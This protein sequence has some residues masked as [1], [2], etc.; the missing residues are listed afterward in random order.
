[1][2]T[3]D[4]SKF[5][6]EQIDKKIKSNSLKKI[7]RIDRS[8]FPNIQITKPD[9]STYN[10]TSFACNDYLG[11]SVNKDVKQAVAQATLTN[12][13]G[14]GGSKFIAGY[15][16]LAKNLEINLAKIKGFEKSIVFSSG[17]L[18][19]I[20]VF[21]SIF[22]QNDIIF[23]D[24]EIHAS[25]IDGILLSKA[26]LI[27]YKHLDLNH[28]S[29]LIQKNKI[30][31][32][33]SCKVA[34]VS[35]SVF[36]MS[37]D[38]QDIQSLVNIA[39]QYGAL[40]IIDDAHGFGVL[41]RSKIINDYQFYIQTGTFSKA[42]GLY[43]GYVCCSSLVATYVQNYARSGIYN[44]FLPPNTIAGIV[45]SLELIDNFDPKLSPVLK[46][47]L[48]CDEFNRLFCSNITTNSAI[49]CIDFVAILQNRLKIQDSY[50]FHL[51]LC[52]FLLLRGM[53]ARAILPPT[54]QRPIVRFTFCSLH[55][56]KVIS[57]LARVCFDFTQIKLSPSL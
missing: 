28:L 21:S 13:L 34:I 57:D 55:S 44:T 10:A 42:V 29:F 16:T 7:V 46:A 30:N 17:Y 43:G 2:N 53:F 20:G 14:S 48:F 39:K 45:K 38:L 3:F 35:E 40:V 49:V 6:N 22:N 56:D 32:N 24:K 31:F 8:N 23:A 15:C 4:L 11:L 27:R 18:A 37:G 5:F 19:N 36:S 26:K 25:I 52:N 47:R 1:M 33:S 9:E 41:Q 51:E 50:L 12:S 54:V